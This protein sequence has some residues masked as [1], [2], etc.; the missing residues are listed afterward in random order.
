MLACVWRARERAA[1]RAAGAAGAQLL[2]LQLRFQL[3][4]ASVTSAC[5]CLRA[6]LQLQKLL[7]LFIAA[8]AALTNTAARSHCRSH[9]RSHVRPDPALC[10]RSTLTSLVLHLDLVDKELLKGSHLH[11]LQ[12]RR[13][14][15]ATKEHTAV[16]TWPPALHSSKLCS[17]LVALAFLWL[18]SAVIALRSNLSRP[19]DAAQLGLATPRRRR[20]R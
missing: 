5:R 16:S 13:Q 17:P 18:C 12:Q 6:R 2:L 1:K 3:L 11:D 9:C 8:R 15:P 4:L 10:P 20:R 19:T 14:H 7:R